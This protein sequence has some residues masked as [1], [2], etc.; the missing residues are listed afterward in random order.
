[1]FVLAYLC[2]ESIYTFYSID[3]GIYGESINNVRSIIILL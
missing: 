3:L 1:M 2:N